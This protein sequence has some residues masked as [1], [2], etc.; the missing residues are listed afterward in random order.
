MRLKQVL[1]FFSIGL[2][3]FSMVSCGSLKKD[4]ANAPT[5]THF[6]VRHAEKVDKSKD[7][8]LTDEGKERAY[9]LATYLKDQPLD[10]V[11]ST[12]FFRT[13]LTGQPTASSKNLKLT[14]YDSKDLKAFAQQVLDQHSTDNLLITGHSNTTPQLAQLLCPESE[15]FTIDHWEYD[16]LFKISYYKD[17][18]CSC[19]RINYGKTSVMH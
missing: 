1:F 10:E 19:E 15:A 3:F 2:L 5:A 7:P 8:G 16:K 14:L 17:G 9:F 13:R 18:T 11:Y 6:L 12:D 4:A